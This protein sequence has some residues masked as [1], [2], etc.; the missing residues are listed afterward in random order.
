MKNDMQMIIRDFPG[1]IAVYAVADIHYGAILH[2]EAGWERFCN[3]ILQEPNAYLI[4]HGDLINNSVRGSV[5]TGVFEDIRPSEQ[6]NRMAEMLRPLQ[7]RIL[8]MV[9]GNHEARSSKDT[10]DCPLYDIACRIDCEDI[11]REN[12]AFLS[13]RIGKRNNSEKANSNQSYKF[14]VVHGSG[15]GTLTGGGVNKAENFARN[16][17]NLDCLVVGHVHKG[18]VTRP[19][20]LVLDGRNGRVVKRDILVVSAVSWMNYGGYALQKMLNPS[21]NSVPQKLILKNNTH[22]S[23]GNGDGRGKYIEVIW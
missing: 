20:K 4:L 17:E 3:Q 21:A 11:Y 5:G 22:R 19:Q 6:K 7:E 2:N 1:E 10:D 13:L 23:V 9:P 18:F 15:G 12:A 8:C 14:A 16:F